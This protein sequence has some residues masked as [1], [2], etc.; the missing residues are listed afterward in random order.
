MDAT[1]RLTRTVQPISA[2]LYPWCLD[3]VTRGVAARHL[4][5]SFNAVLVDV[6][7]SLPRPTP[8]PRALG[9]PLFQLASFALEHLLDLVEHLLLLF[10]AL[11][12]F[13]SVGWSDDDGFV[14]DHFLVV[15]ADRDV[16]AYLY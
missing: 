7:A 3:C 13:W 8:H 1:A 14:D 9:F 12:I 11:A 16:A 6:S 10:R 15:P 4:I 5:F 2:A